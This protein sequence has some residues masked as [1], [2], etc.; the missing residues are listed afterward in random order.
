MGGL[1][2]LIEKAVQDGVY[3]GCALSAVDK[4]GKLSYAKAFGKTGTTSNAGDF[5]LDTVL[6]IASMTKLLTTIAVLQLVEKGEVGLDDDV[7]K[8]VPELVEQGVLKNVGDDGK[9]ETVPIKGKLTLRHLLTH[10]AGCCYDAWNPTIQKVKGYMGK[11]KQGGATMEERAL[12]PLL[13][14]PGTSWVYSTSIDWAGRVLERITGETLDSYMAKNMW[15]QLGVKD[16]TFYPD[17][18]PEMKKRLAE[19]TGRDDKSGRVVNYPLPFL[20]TGSVDCFGGHGGYSTVEEY[21]KVLQSILVN[22]EKLLKKETVE[23]MFKP[24]LTQESRAA[25]QQTVNTPEIVKLFIGDFP[26]SKQYDWGLGGILVEKDNEGRRR[27]DTLIWS[28]M[29][30][31]FWF[32]DREAGV[33]GVFGTQVLPPGDSMVEET[34]KTF[35][36]DMNER[37]SKL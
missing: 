24:Q 4:S 22:D 23:Q 16:F 15:P 28:G 33:C 17:K 8:H 20:N 10:S 2:Q 25:L 14:E 11:P 35:E 7:V 30:N 6:Q 3:T 36:Y 37:L 13:Y 29:P 9:P 12:Y 21:I 1:D 18:H 27:K 26:D 34:I 5:K 32:I 19:L 31:C